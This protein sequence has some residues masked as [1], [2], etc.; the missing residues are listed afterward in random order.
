MKFFQMNSGSWRKS[1]VFSRTVLF[2]YVVF[3]FGLAQSLYAGAW[4]LKK[5]Q[6]WAKSSFFYQKT[7]KRYY[8]RNILCPLEHECHSSG[9]KVPFPFDG[10]SRFSALYL[11]LGYGVTDR[12]E[13]RVQIPYFDIE[14][15]DLSNPL[16]PNSTGV[17]D[18]RFGFGYNFLS[19]PIV[20]TLQIRAKA[21]TGFFN[22]ES[23]VVPIGDGQWDLE[24]MGQF[25][26]SLW[27]IAG[28]L[29]VDVGYRL[30]FAPD[31]ET[32]TI[33]PG[34]E[35]F[36][37]G[38][39]GYSV[40]KN[41]LFKVA[42]FGTYGEKIIQ[43]SLTIPDSQ[44]EILF[45]EPGVFLTIRKNIALESSVMF[46]L[47]GKNFPAGQVFNFGLSYTFSLLQ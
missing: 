15:T 19:N 47:A 21:P 12:L 11:D 17:G 10:E 16:R 37:R 6:L 2:L 23:E 40:L 18:V 29:N 32:T 3:T 26:K 7:T 5:G 34:N 8:S 4:T 35:F 41:L 43:E 33:E 39:A 14:F 27:P 13:L 22:K 38:E 46:S 45:F 20:S 1:R 44:R 31:V 36:F 42:L 28:Y 25:G 30:R 9:Q 24:F